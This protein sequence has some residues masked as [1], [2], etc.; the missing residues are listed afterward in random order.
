MGYLREC[1][2]G[3]M[4]MSVRYALLSM[5]LFFYTVH[6]EKAP[7][8]VWHFLMLRGLVKPYEHKFLKQF[9][10][11]QRSCTLLQL[12]AKVIWFAKDFATYKVAYRQLTSQLV[13]IYRRQTE[14]F[15]VMEFPMPFQYF[16][17][18]NIMITMN[19]VM[20]AYIMAVAQSTFAPLC[21]FFAA[22]IF[23]GL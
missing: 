5:V 8:A 22:M 19:L 18:L 14:I 23:M 9:S 16:H 15:D 4:R 10:N 6:G 17:I 3:Y 1:P 2:Q 7:A 13:S 20:W 11:P 21:Y 12:S